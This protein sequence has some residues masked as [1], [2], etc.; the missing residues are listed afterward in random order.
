MN[1]QN[2]RQCPA[3]GFSF[4][5]VAAML[6][7][8]PAKD[9]DWIADRFRAPSL[10]QYFSFFPSSSP[11]PNVLRCKM[12]VGLRFLAPA[13]RLASISLRHRLFIFLSGTKALLLKGRWLSPGAEFA[14]W[15]PK[16]SNW[17]SEPLER[18]GIS[19]CPLCAPSGTRCR[20]E[21]KLRVGLVTVGWRE[22]NK[23][24]CLILQSLAAALAA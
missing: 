11:P 6:D 21:G 1:L 3:G 18:G 2:H 16:T 5:V 15:R 19:V 13:G 22:G 8:L 7:R 14:P 24:R 20:G 12:P 17:H 10:R 4:P 23:N 9:P